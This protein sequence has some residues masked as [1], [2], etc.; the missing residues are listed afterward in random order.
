MADTVAEA[1]QA[2]LDHMPTRVLSAEAV[3]ALI[4]VVREDVRG[5]W[6]PEYRAIL[7]R[8]AELEGALWEIAKDCIECEYRG[9]TCG[10][11]VQ[12]YAREVLG[13]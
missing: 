3:D 10:H 2:V 4:E 6:R 9:V 13:E 11:W 12:R 7:K 5:E 8:V 1:R